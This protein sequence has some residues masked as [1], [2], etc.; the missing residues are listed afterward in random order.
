MAPL[1][2]KPQ[3]SPPL[4]TR[5]AYETGSSGG[6]QRKEPGSEALADFFV[7]WQLDVV[8]GDSFKETGGALTIP[9]DADGRNP[10]RAS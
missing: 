5:L 8:T 6:S 4:Q 10:V 3:F 1:E 2:Q 9:P 7:E